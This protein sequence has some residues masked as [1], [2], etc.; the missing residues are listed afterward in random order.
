MLYQVLQRY[1]SYTIYVLFELYGYMFFSIQ[2]FLKLS[3]GFALQVI[4][5]W[6]SLISCT[7]IPMY[8]KVSQSCVFLK[9]M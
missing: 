5:Y 2:D 9:I 8:V 1:L 7:L 4:M 3:L 6:T